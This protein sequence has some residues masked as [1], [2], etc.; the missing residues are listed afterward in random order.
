MRFA[1]LLAL[2]VITLFRP[3]WAQEDAASPHRML[4]PD[5]AV[6]TEKCSV[7]HSSDMSLARPKAEVCTLCH[8]PTIHSGAVEHLQESPASVT[9]L[10]GGKQAE[11]ALPL[12]ENGAIY[13]GT[14]HLFHDPR[15]MTGEQPQAQAWVPSRTGLAAAVRDDLQRLQPRVAQKY[16][17]SSPGA[18]LATKGTRMLRLPVA[19]GTLCL[20]CHRT[21][22]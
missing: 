22:P 5:G 8:S 10:L 17:A 21:L 20:H 1:P 2:A 12:T 15:V 6:D 16:G 13:C 4:K 18:T 19:D 3:I 7:C 9:A 14:C 11:P